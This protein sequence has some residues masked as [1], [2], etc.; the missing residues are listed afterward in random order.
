MLDGSCS[1]DVNKNISSYLWTKISGP[2]SFN[3]ANANVVQTQLTNLVEGI[4]LFQLRV[5]DAGGL[6]SMD[7]LQVSVVRQNNSLV[8]VYV[9]GSE[10]GVAKYWKNGQEVILGNQ[11]SGESWAS[12]IAVV[13][14]NVYVAGG[15][16]DWFTPGSNKAEF[17]KNG[18]GLVLNI[19]GDAGATSITVAGSDVYVA[20]WEYSGIMTVAKYWKNSQQVSI[21]LTNGVTDAV[22]TCIV[23]VEGNI[24]VSGYEGNEAKYWKNGQPVSLTNGLGQAFANSIAV[25][26]NDIY[27]AGSENNVAKY[28]KNGQAISLTKGSAIN[29]TAN[30]IAVVGN[31]VYV[32]GWEG[33]YPGRVG[34]LGSVAKYWKNGQEIS[35]TNGTNYAYAT[36]IAVYDG[37]VYVAGYEGASSDKFVA[38]YWKN[39]QA[40]PVS[41]ADGAFATGILVVPR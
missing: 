22:A 30:G 37:D 6:F 3:I 15:E 31:D 36:S 41:G 16:G 28:W 32:V 27:V 9:S 29:A 18:Q 7:T 23:V 20:G 25:V 10:K 13:G 12:S 4:F 8:D 24:Y 17:W 33:D 39:G 1:Y 38:K 19:E 2:S 5:T 35:L 14:N 34:G 40:V 26:G 11:Q 21:A